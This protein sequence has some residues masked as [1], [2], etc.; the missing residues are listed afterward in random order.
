MRRIGAVLCL[1]MLVA[2]VIVL[3]GCATD[4]DGKRLFVNETDG[5]YAQI[6][7]DIMP[8]YSVISA[9]A[10]GV[11]VSP[12]KNGTKA[13]TVFDVQADTAEKNGFCRYD[14]FKTAAVI[15]VDR[16]ACKDKLSGWRDLK[17]LGC[18]VG[19]SSK[20]DGRMLFAAVSYAL[21]KTYLSDEA[22]DIFASLSR[23]G[24]FDFGGDDAPVSVC[25]DFQAAQM[26]K[27][28]PN[29]EIIIPSEGTIIY[30]MGI[31][32]ERPIVFPSDMSDRLFAAGFRS[33]ERLPELY[34]DSEDYE[35]AVAVTDYEKFSHETNNF[36]ATLKRKI[37]RTRLYS[38][39]DSFE[40]KLI[41]VAV[42]AASLL[43]MGYSIRGVQHRNIKK[44]FAAMGSMVISWLLVTALKYQCDAFPILG[45]YCW[46]A[47]YIFMMGLPL[48]MLLLSA[49]IDIPENARLP[50]AAVHSCLTVYAVLLI[51]VFTNDIHEWV[52]KFGTDG[53]YEYR[54]GYYMIFIFVAFCILLSTVTL[55]KKA[56]RGFGRAG[57]GLPIVFELLLLAYCIAYITD[58]PAIRDGD[59]TLVSCVFSL[60]FAGVA[61]KTGLIPV[62]TKYDLLFSLSPLK[63]QILDSSGNVSLQSAGADV[64]PEDIKSELLSGTDSP[65]LQDDDVLL[66]ADSIPGGTVVWQE[67]I[68]EILKMQ[69]EIQENVIKLKA[70]NKL[71]LAERENKYRLAAAEEK[72][73][74][75]DML[76]DEIKSHLETMR[77][78]L[79]ALENSENRQKDIAKI[80]LLLCYI[81][82]RCNL[83]FKEQEGTQLPVE[84]IAVYIDELSEFAA[85]AD[86]RVA[87]ACTATGDVT[88]R[89][90]TVIYDF[91]YRILEM[92][93]DRESTVLE[94]LIDVENGVELKLLSSFFELDASFTE[95][96]L[97]RELDLFDCK[98]TIKE[99]DETAGISLFVPKGGGEE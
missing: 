18:H 20:T 38:A 73:R 1:I 79:G 47:Y 6:L 36:T 94:Q 67:N 71:L 91:F 44:L 99:L 50:K 77:R 30:S 35:R 82:R 63:M 8:D 24:L 51:M 84:E 78:M 64:I 62:N 97:K 37:M 86:V 53:K 45:R 68:S 16:S 55:I 92:C 59:M 88:P 2:A 49:V 87:T 7:S 65:L 9:D 95:D 56:M 66:F 27:K 15:A 14:H 31:V 80:T 4:T 61:V 11:S 26:K 75:M 70:A 12:T 83:F 25:W 29:V 93:S 17:N 89:R 10:N 43:W 48:M 57:L 54:F 19:F 22:T 40:H 3:P 23:R 34:P 85:Y 5:A 46:Y 69:K 21:D 81:K 98:I 74:L 60:I 96:A 39:A 28:N 41:T 76:S 33:D 32:S 58:V 42:I 52:F 90:G 72:I 13:M